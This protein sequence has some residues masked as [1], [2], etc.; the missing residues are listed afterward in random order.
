MVNFSRLVWLNIWQTYI[1]GKIK[2]YT[3]IRYFRL[4]KQVW[5][6][7]FAY[8]VNKC[9]QKDDI[10]LL[11][12]MSGCMDDNKLTREQRYLYV[13]GVPMERLLKLSEHQVKEA[14]AKLKR[15]SRLY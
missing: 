14:V 3:H 1:T 12:G 13:R 10:N 8:G 9:K 2:R 7:D 15:A 5:Q 4:Q 6:D 11:K